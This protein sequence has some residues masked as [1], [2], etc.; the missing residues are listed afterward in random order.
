MNKPLT[1]LG[2]WSLLTCAVALL[3]GCPKNDDPEPSTEMREYAIQ[4]TNLTYAQPVSPLVA[5]LHNES[6]R[7]MTVGAAASA[8]LEQLAESGANADLLAQLNAN[9]MTFNNVGGAGVLMPGVS[10][11][12]TVSA[13]FDAA[14]LA[15][16][17][18]SAVTMLVNTNDAITGFNGLDV[19]NLAVGDSMSLTTL[20]YDAGTEANTE[21]ADTV[22]GPAAAGGAQEGFNALRDDI[23][24]EVAMHAGVLTSDEG[25]MT[26]VLTHAHR[27][28][29]PV[30]RVVVTRMQ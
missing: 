10:E 16:V 19:T 22:P 17:Q 7:L 3:A 27:F 23:R 13:E 24:D 30:L 18:L 2:R 20:A 6:V 1:L 12:L 4:V 29:N 15:S 25:L 9:S 11:T 5:S 14:Q 28:D 26:S 21:S 8:A